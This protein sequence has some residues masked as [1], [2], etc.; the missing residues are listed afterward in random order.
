MPAQL[1]WFDEAGNFLAELTFPMTS[2]GQSRTQVLLYRNTGDAP[3][4]NVELEVGAVGAADMEAW[5][6]AEVEGVGAARAGMPLRLGDLPSGAAGRLTLTLAVPQDAPLSS[7]PVM[8]SCAVT[9]DQ[10]A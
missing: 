4:T 6:T 9:Y 2:P 8:A 10:D 3:A 5:L 7:R 1:E